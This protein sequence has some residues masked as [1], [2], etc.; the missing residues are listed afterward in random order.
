MRFFSLILS[1]FDH[2]TAAL[3]RT[4]TRVGDKYKE[5][6]K[7]KRKPRRREKKDKGE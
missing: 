5:K 2:H 3:Y 1:A 4:V 6:G 7:N